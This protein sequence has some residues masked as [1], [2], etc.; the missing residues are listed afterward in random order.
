M[1]PAIND[2]SLKLPLIQEHMKHGWTKTMQVKC[3]VWGQSTGHHVTT[4]G[5][6]PA[7][8]GVLAKHQL[9]VPMS[10]VIRIILKDCPF[11]SYKIGEKKQ[12]RNWICACSIDSFILILGFYVFDRAWI[13]Q[14]FNHFQSV[15]I[16]VINVATH[17]KILVF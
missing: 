2:W 12:V 10:H 7:T 4:D 13:C 14:L 1:F 6:E 5:L 11:L 16:R 3:L 15:W 9:N 8:F 17:D